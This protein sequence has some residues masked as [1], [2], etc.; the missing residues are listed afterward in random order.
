MSKWFLK[1]QFWLKLREE[2]K[3]KRWMDKAHK[4]IIVKRVARAVAYK[5]KMIACFGLYDAKDVANVLDELGISY[6]TE[7]DEEF[8][9][10]KLNETKD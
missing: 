8:I 10:I 3:R 7:K 2:R 9:Y 4:Y 5:D 1:A 6:R